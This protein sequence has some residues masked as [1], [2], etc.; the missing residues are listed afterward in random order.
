MN[1]LRR[2]VFILFP[3]LTFFV[4]SVIAPDLLD[5]VFRESLIA[6]SGHALTH[7]PQDLQASALAA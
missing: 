3:Q 6:F 4:S 2:K 5:H 7:R 1:D